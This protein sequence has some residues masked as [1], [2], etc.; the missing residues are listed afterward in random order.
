MKPTLLVAEGD[1]D[2]REIYRRF[3]TERNY[4]VATAVDG[5]ECLEKLRR[6]RPA[7]LVLDWELRWG[8]G[9]GVLTWLREQDV[10]SGTSVVVTSK[11]GCPSDVFDDIRP[12]VVRWLLKPFALTALLESVDVPFAEGQREERCNLN[13]A[14]ACSDRFTR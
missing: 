7:V 8:G 12:P 5:L 9:D 14:G 11:A 1:A 10:G 4:A 6:L 2:L 3:L 13:R